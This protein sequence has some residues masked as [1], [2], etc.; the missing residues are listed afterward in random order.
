M[1]GKN[2]RIYQNV[3]IGQ[4]LSPT[5]KI[6]GAPVIGDNALIGAGVVILGKIRI[7]NNVTVGANAVVIKDVPDGQVVVGV[8]K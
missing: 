7:G 5:D 6:D 8:T 2:C 4:K 1:I 3:T